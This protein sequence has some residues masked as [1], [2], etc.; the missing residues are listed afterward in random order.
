MSHLPGVVPQVHSS[1]LSSSS[2]S[3]RIASALQIQKDKLVSPS[4]IM[5]TH[6]GSV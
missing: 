3:N 6:Q 5:A 1:K 4:Q 2:G